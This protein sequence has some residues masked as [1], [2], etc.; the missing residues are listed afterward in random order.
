MNAQRLW[1]SYEEYFSKFED[2][3]D[4]AGDEMR[5]VIDELKSDSESCVCVFRTIC[6]PTI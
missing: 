2:Y 4:S 3:R 6:I 5:S 1:D